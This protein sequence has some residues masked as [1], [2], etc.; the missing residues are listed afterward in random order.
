MNC[1]MKAEKTRALILARGVFSVT[2]VPDDSSEHENCE[3]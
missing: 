3:I 1:V 2:W